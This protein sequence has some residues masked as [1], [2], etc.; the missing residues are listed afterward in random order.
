MAADAQNLVT[1]W[2]VIGDQNH[3]RLLSLSFP[4]Q[5][6]SVEY[7]LASKYDFRFVVAEPA[8]HFVKKWD[9]TVHPCNSWVASPCSK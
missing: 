3:F 5:V 9:P 1:I 4:W 2:V 6:I 7:F 8:R